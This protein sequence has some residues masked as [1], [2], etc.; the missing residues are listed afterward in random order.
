MLQGMGSLIAEQCA[1]AQCMVLENSTDVYKSYRSH[2]NQKHITMQNKHT[3]RTC[4]LRK[5]GGKGGGGWRRER[6]LSYLV[7]EVL[8]SL[9][10]LM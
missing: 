1:G 3:T 8:F 5:E 6:D 9:T 10:L 2:C 7:F 4:E